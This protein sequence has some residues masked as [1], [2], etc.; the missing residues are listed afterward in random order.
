MLFFVLLLKVT[1]IL[2]A[3]GG[4]HWTYEGEIG[5]PDGLALL[6]PWGPSPGMKTCPKEGKSFS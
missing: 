2:A 1:W 3:D 4:H 6:S 5:T